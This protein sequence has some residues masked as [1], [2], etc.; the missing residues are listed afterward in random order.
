MTS[1]TPEEHPVY[2]KAGVYLPLGNN[3]PKAKITDREVVVVFSQLECSY[4]H[5]P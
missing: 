5:R 4:G 3:L 2:Y 1:F